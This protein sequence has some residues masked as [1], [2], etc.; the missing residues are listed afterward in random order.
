MAESNFQVVVRG[1]NLP[2]AV[3]SV[4]LGSRPFFANL[5]V[6]KKKHSP[7]GR[8]SLRTCER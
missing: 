7:I 2:V 6:E 4:G 3:A 1:F 5:P 8:V